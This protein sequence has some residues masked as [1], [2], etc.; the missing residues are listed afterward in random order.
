MDI[1]SLYT[2]IPNGE[3]LLALKHFFDLRAVKEPSSETLLRLAKPVSIL[4]W[5]SFADNYFKQ[6]NGVAMGTKM[7]PS[8]ANLLVGYVEYQF[9]INIMAP[10]LNSTVATLTA[11]SAL[12]LLPERTSINL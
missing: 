1:T 9:L 4:N 8:Y 11:V 6:I 3:G 7:E 12:P 5:F 10:N 2:V